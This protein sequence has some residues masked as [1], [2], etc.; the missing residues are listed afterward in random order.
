MFIIVVCLLAH[1]QGC[2]VNRLTVLCLVAFFSLFLLFVIFAFVG[3]FFS[4][5][6]LFF[7]LNFFVIAAHILLL[8]SILLPSFFF[9]LRISLAKILQGRDPYIRLFLLLLKHIT[10]TSLIPHCTR[11]APVCCTTPLII[12]TFI[13]DSQKKKKENKGEAGELLHNGALWCEL[14]FKKFIR[15]PKTMIIISY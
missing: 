7:C 15:H 2:D 8:L 12:S 4:R 11:E 5:F 3:F 10:L 9:L 6:F 1:V 13:T 14:D